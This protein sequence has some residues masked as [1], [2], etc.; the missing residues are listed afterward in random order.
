MVSAL[1][2]G[3]SVGNLLADRDVFG[4]IGFSQTM[5]PSMH[6]VS[7]LR[8]FQYLLTSG[9]LDP[10]YT[11][12]AAG[13]FLKFINERVSE[14]FVRV[15][16][17]EGSPSKETHLNK[18]DDALQ[19]FIDTGLTQSEAEAESSIFLFAGT[20]TTATALRH[21]IFYLCAANPA[22]YRTLQAEIDDAA[23]AKSAPLDSVIS[24][25]RASSLPFLQACIKETMRMWP[26]AQTF[27]AKI[28]DAD[29]VVCGL[30]VPAGTQVGWAALA[31]MRDSEIFGADADMFEPRRWVDV[32]EQKLREMEAVY[33]LVFAVGTRW[34]CPGRKLA[35]AELGKALFD[36]GISFC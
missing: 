15:R 2:F 33:G 10:G 8:P 16:A 1:G 13:Q 30:R 34:E 23:A 25:D 14:S 32:K 4:L 11:D 3:R 5:I 19:S 20:D 18:T 26:P 31:V 21:A 6:V 29:D 27:M 22:A 28:S 9:M 7:Y 24:A 36:V 35:V 17:T 12:H